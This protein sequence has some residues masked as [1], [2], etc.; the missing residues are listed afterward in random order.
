MIPTSGGI[1]LAK[2]MKKEDYLYISAA[3]RAREPRMLTREKAERM[4]EAPEFVDSAKLLT[5][6][7]YEDMSQMNASEIDRALTAHRAEIFAEL[8]RQLPDKSLLDVFRV[9]YDYHNAK[10]VLKAEAMGTEALPVMSTTSQSGSK[11]SQALSG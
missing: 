8:D 2:A 11:Y 7:G 6:C 1:N 10:T 4:L 3:L 9:K 5:D